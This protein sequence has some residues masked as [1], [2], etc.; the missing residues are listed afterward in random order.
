MATAERR[1]RVEA[2]LTDYL[3]SEQG[4]DSGEAQHKARTLLD[5]ASR[6]RSS[7]L[8]Y[9]AGH[10]GLLALRGV[11]ALIAAYAF[12][13]SP[14]SALGTLALLFAA[15]VFVDGIF[16]LAGAFS[17]RSWLLGLSGAV[18][19]AVGWW[20]LSRPA[21][22]AL[23]MFVLIAA[24]AVARGVTEIAFAVALPKGVSG[25]GGI[26]AV[27]ILSCL[28]GILLIAAPFAGVMALSAWIGVYAL[29]FGIME[30][31]IAFSLLRARRQMKKGG[32]GMHEGGGLWQ[33]HRT[34]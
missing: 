15:W 18:S 14:A 31:T 4:I 8:A 6:A 17:E 24:W 21:G 12:F 16:S 9:A 25:K 7:A 13:A 32:E 10:W 23:V 34:A 5:G 29:L 20:M 11:V 30:L 33:R 2:A 1:G 28:F 26:V 22:A 27:G 19:I 3:I